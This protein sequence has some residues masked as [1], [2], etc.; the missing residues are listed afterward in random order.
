MTKQQ[1]QPKAIYAA[2]IGTGETVPVL[3]ISIREIPPSYNR[4]Y[5]ERT[6]IRYSGIN[7][8]TGRNVDIKSAQRIYRQ[9]SADDAY[10]QYGAKPEY[11]AQYARYYEEHALVKASFMAYVEREKEVG[12]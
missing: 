9:I 4:Y 7:L 10:A 11:L 1:V 2:R 8:K 3:L 6:R 5:E 12:E